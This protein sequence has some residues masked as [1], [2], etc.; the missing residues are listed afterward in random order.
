[1]EFY[2]ICFIEHHNV[3]VTLWTFFTRPLDASKKLYANVK[4][5]FMIPSS[6]HV[7]LHIYMFTSSQ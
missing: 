1:M 7:Y 2:N 6:Y 5:V 3:D 4:A